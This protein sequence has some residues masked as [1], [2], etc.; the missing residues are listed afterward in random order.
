MSRAVRF[1]PLALLLLVIAGLV[2]RLSTPADTN[3]RS[4]LAGKPVPAFN[5]AAPLPGKPAFSSRDLAMGRPRLVNIFASWCVPCIT[6]VKVLKQLQS[7]GV[8]IDGIAIRDRAGD[9]AA[10]LARNGD[11]YARI[12]SDEQSAL[13]IALGSSGVPES[14]VVDGRGIIR[15]QHIGAVEA[16]DVPLI[17]SQLE[18]AR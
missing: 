4:R 7:R 15:Y 8:A 18:Q 14:F 17:L 6:E 3:V 11:P 13:Q 12:G 5:L 2:W 10:F 9:I 1:A 16:A